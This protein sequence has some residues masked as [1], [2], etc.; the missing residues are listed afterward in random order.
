MKGVDNSNHVGEWLYTKSMNVF[1]ARWTLLAGFFIF[2]VALIGIWSVVYARHGSAA[3]GKTHTAIQWSDQLGAG[4]AFP[5]CG[6]SGVGLDSS[7]VSISAPETVTAGTQFSASITM[8]NAGEYGWG[9]ISTDSGFFL[10]P[11]RV[12]VGDVSPMIN[13]NNDIWGNGRAVLPAG[14]TVNSGAN[15]IFSGTFTAPTTPGTYPFDVRMVADGYQWFGSTCT[16][17][18]TVTAPAACTLPWGGTLANGSSVTAYQASSVNSGDTCNSQTRTC[19]NGTLSGSY[20]NQSCTVVYPSCTLPWGGTLANGS[21]VTAY[22]SPTAISPITCSSISETRTCTNGTLSGSYTNQSCT[23]VYPSCTL[24]WGGTLAN[25]SSVTAYQASSVNSGDTCN[26]QTRTCT[27]GTLSGSYTNQSCTV[28]YPSCTLPWGG[29]LA[30]GSSVTAYQ[31]SS[32]NS[33][34]TCNSQTRTCTN[35]TLSGSYTNQ[36]CTVVY[37]SCTLPWGGTLANG[38][39]VT[40]YQSPT[41]ISPI[42][43]SSISETRTCTNGTLS[44][45]YTNQNCSQVNPPT[46]TTF[47]PTPSSINPGGSSTLTWT[48]TGAT[49][50]TGIGFTAGATSGSAVVS[51]STTSSYQLQCTGP[52]GTT[53]V[54]TA[55]VTVLV[56]SASISATPD[57]VDAGK[58]TTISWNNVGVTDCSAKKNGVNMFKG[59]F[60]TTTAGASQSIASSTTDTITDQTTYEILCRD[61]PNTSKY[62]SA[63]QIVNVSTTG[64]SEF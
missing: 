22:Q 59:A 12:G 40:A 48:S 34:D 14:S 16:E 3:A 53:P 43:C 11:D 2:F 56:P 49:S 39:S 13:D 46:V 41:A 19:T 24:P 33:G 21:S 32:V 15:G 63:T 9:P 6:S 25:G 50:C 18:I 5:A 31:A 10:W 28:V 45:S 35:G 8:L 23:V 29:T 47:N 52:G 64:F 58:T 51:P 42:T 17:N 60:A 62:V 57:R 54:S 37:P 61:F 30:N 20:T 27:N 44:G 4:E 38:S 1:R 26:S 55:T 36:S 7:C